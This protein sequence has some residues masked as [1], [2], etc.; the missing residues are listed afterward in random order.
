MRHYCQCCDREFHIDDE[1]TPLGAICTACW[2]EEDLLEED[3]WSSANGS[4]LIE[5]KRAWAAVKKDEPKL[6][7]HRLVEAIWVR[8]E[9]DRDQ[10]AQAS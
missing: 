5:W 10:L 4:T 7:D 3:G 8:L 1:G 9:A 6:P 2:W